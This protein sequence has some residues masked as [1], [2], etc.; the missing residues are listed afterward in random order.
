V[1]YGRWL[2][3]PAGV[4]PS[5]EGVRGAAARVLLAGY[6]E[7][8]PPDRSLADEELVAL[9]GC[10]GIEIARFAVAGD[11]EQ[12]VHHA[13]DI[14]YPVALKVFD[15]ELR[16]RFDQFGVRLAL[17]DA[18]AVRAAY[19]ELTARDGAGRPAGPARTQVYVQQMAPRDRNTVG[20]VLRIISDPSFGALVSFG[21]GGVATELLGDLAYQAVPLTDS[22]AADLI[23]APRAAPLLTGYRGAAVVDRSALLDLVLRLSALADDLPEISELTLQPVLLGP[24]GHCVTGATGRIGSPAAP[25]D[26]RRRL[27]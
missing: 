5:L 23:D 26:V 11:A 4:V 6:R 10:Y 1:A 7:Q 8:G 2:G 17:P 9:L 22:D 21:V 20:T 13:A 16:H 27:R 12:A 25:P 15:P 3:R 19:A 18:G 14:G 24:A